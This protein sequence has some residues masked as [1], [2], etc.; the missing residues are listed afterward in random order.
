[1]KEEK[2]GFPVLMQ[3][4]NRGQIMIKLTIRKEIGWNLTKLWHFKVFWKCVKKRA[5]KKWTV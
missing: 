3:N 1:V 2:V 5:R 4:E